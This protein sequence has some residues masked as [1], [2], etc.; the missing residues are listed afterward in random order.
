MGIDTFYSDHWKEIEDERVTRY[1]AMF[2][3]RDAHAVMLES[4][5]LEPG[6]KVL[7]YGSG[8]GFMSLGMGDMVGPTGEVHGVDLNARFV[9]DANERAEGK[10]HVTFHQ[11]DGQSIPLADA[12]VDRVVCKNVL[13]Y[14]P[15]ASAALA[16]FYRVLAPGGRVLVIDS[17]WGFVLVQ[18]WGDAATRAFF[19]AAAP[20]SLRRVYPFHSPKC[21]V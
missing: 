17:D 2:Q 5:G 1:E 21:S 6:S 11:G 16:E 13:E 4:L 10:P 19:E 12:S 9:A 20:A 8:P 3:W 18:P 14:V 15:D 7:D